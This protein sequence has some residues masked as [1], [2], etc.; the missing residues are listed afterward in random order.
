MEKKRLLILFLICI[1]PLASATT[2]LEIQT[3]PSKDIWI[4]AQDIGG[5]TIKVPE[6]YPSNNCG[7]LKMDYMINES[8]FYLMIRIKEGNS[9]FFFKRYTSKFYKDQLINLTALPEGH[10]LNLPPEC[11]PDYV[12]K[13]TPKEENSTETNQSLNE[14]QISSITGYTFFKENIFTKDNWIYLIFI[15]LIAIIAFLGFK[16]IKQERILPS[17]KSPHNKNKEKIE[18]LENKIAKYE[19][20]IRILKREQLE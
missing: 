15:L 12:E 20:K 17:S 9:L 4:T 6:S 8:D 10:I 3:A 14:S 16:N 18:N 2:V 13:V 19:N 1:F 5:N 11:S 7:K